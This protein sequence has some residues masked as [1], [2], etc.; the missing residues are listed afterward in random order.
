M[1]YPIIGHH[2][3][4]IS[5]QNAIL[6]ANESKFWLDWFEVYPKPYWWDLTDTIALYLS[7]YFKEISPD[8]ILPTLWWEDAINTLFEYARYFN[9]KIII[10]PP[11][12]ILYEFYAERKC[13]KIVKLPLDKNGQ[14]DILVF[15]NLEWHKD[16]YMVFISSPWNPSWISLD[17]EDIMTLL[18]EWYFVILDEAYI[19]FIWLEHSLV[20]NIKTF[21]NLVI[22]HSFSKGFSVPWLRLG[23]LIWHELNIRTLANFCYPYWI[24]EQQ[25]NIW[26]LILKDFSV[27]ENKLKFVLDNRN[28]LYI[29]LK[30]QNIFETVINT[31]A[32]FLLVKI[33]NNRTKDLYLYLKNNWVLVLYLEEGFWYL[34]WFIRISIWT[35]TENDLLIKTIC[36]Y[37]HSR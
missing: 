27:Y 23:Y 24:T 30:K 2:I 4:D 21:R 3:S 11:S 13:L 7:S 32:N 35:N 9:K 8:N 5:K 36:N 25:S 10:T 15:Q 28:Y 33:K 37:E 14:L 6:D 26:K 17:P 20:R 31:D 18:T 22:I 19:H 29:L 16:D 1:R 12:F 34:D